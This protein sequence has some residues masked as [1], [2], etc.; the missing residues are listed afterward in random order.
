MQIGRSLP[1]GIKVINLF[2][3]YCI[4]QWVV[5]QAGALVAYDYVSSLGLHPTRDQ[6]DPI[7]V[8]VTQGIAF[9]DVAI[10]LPLFIIGLVGLWRLKAYGLTAAWIAL[11]INIYWPA[12]AWA[13]RYFYIQAGFDTEPKG[14]FLNS[15]LAFIALFS[16]WAI[17][18]LHKNRRLFG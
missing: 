9:A 10:Q 2:L 11:G 8:A 5:G 18:Y 12:V 6:S 7:S 14:L 16:I 17:W 4:L 15:A 13:K 3:I 1:I